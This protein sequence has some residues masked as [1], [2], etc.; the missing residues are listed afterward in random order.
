MSRDAAR[1]NYERIVIVSRETGSPVPVRLSLVPDYPASKDELEVI[2]LKEGDRRPPPC[3]WTT[4]R[5]A[6]GPL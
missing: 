6:S 1:A 2:A 5:P 3:H 4:P